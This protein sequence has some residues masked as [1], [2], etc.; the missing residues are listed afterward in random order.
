MVDALT[1]VNVRFV[2]GLRRRIDAVGTL[3]KAVPKFIVRVPLVICVV[4]LIIPAQ[5]VL[6]VTV[7]SVGVVAPSALNATAGEVVCLAIRCAAF[8]T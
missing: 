5:S 1:E 2:S 8:A 4:R 6:L 3:A 7:F